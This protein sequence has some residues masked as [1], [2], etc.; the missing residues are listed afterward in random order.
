MASLTESF[1]DGVLQGADDEVELVVLVGRLTLELAGVGS[2]DGLLVH[3]DRR[4]RDDVDA[5]LVLD[6]VLGDLQVELSHSG[7]QV[8]AGLVVDLDVQRGVGLG[9][10]PE[11]LDQLGMTGSE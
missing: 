1:L 5:L 7:H 4:G 11:N 2:L 3:D 10:D 9:D 8:L 6:P